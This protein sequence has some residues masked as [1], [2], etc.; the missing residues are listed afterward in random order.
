MLSAV[1]DGGWQRASNE[2]IEQLQVPQAKPQ[3][4]ALQRL[5]PPRPL[6]AGVLRKRYEVTKYLSR[7]QVGGRRVIADVTEEMSPAQGFSS[8]DLHDPLPKS[9]AES[10]ST[11]PQARAMSPVRQN[12][13]A[14]TVHEPHR[15]HHQSK[16][17]LFVP[18]TIHAEAVSSE[19]IQ[20]LLTS[21]EADYGT[22]N[23]PTSSKG[24]PASAGSGGR[25]IARPASAASTRSA[26]T[27]QSTAVQT[28]TPAHAI[29]NAMDDFR[30]EK[31]LR[32]Y[33]RNIDANTLRKAL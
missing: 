2:L 7:E 27:L 24:R 3:P 9:V 23:R 20:R 16:D 1:G 29:A 26:G 28:S 15:D 19:A 22:G 8:L 5:L 6:S 31:R 4:S 21:L 12:S 11:T 25:Y 10:T 17:G 33:R 32:H 14:T 18:P 30:E 13:E